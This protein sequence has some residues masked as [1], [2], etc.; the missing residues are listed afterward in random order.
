MASVTELT[1]IGSR[2][3]CSIGEWPFWWMGGEMWCQG[4]APRPRGAP[5]PTDEGGRAVG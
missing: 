3:W 2:W 1:E 4:A 5:G